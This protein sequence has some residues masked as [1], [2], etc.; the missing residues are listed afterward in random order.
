MKRKLAK[1]VVFLLLGAVVNVVVAWAAANTLDLAR[2]DYS[3]SFLRADPIDVSAERSHAQLVSVEL[4][5]SRLYIMKK[6]SAAD[7]VPPG[8]LNAA[9]SSAGLPSWVKA[10]HHIFAV[11][12][13]YEAHGWP[14][15]ALS[16]AM[17]IDDDTRKMTIVDRAIT[18]GGPPRGEWMMQPLPRILPYGIVWPGFAIN[19]VFYAVTLWLLLFNLSIVRRYARFKRGHCPQCRYDLRGDSSAGCPECGWRREDVP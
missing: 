2:V 7:L 19:T 12:R 8:A 10:K 14:C 11:A 13:I 17:F 18:L 5:A 3:A 9:M 6:F 15:V 1:L 16:S 4:F